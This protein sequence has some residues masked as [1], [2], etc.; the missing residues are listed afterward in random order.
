M[1]NQVQVMDDRQEEK[2]EK[3]PYS[4]PMLERLGSVEHVTQG[5]PVGGGPDPAGLSH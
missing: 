3:K 2:A 5:M 1:E 4:P